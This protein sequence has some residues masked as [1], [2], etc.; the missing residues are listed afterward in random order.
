MNVKIT[1]QDKYNKM[2]DHILLPS[3]AQA[4]AEAGQSWLYY[5][6]NPA[7]QPPTNPEKY[8]IATLDESV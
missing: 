3:S 7:T 5:Q 2:N 6:L 1:C 8:E 4:Q